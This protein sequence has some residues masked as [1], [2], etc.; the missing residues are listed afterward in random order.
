[1]AKK[2][3]LELGA[4]HL[5]HC[6]ADEF[7]YADT[8]TIKDSLDIAVDVQY[9]EVINYLPP[10]RQA[11]KFII[12]KFNFMN[13]KYIVSEPVS[14]SN[15]NKIKS[16]QLLLYKYPKKVLTNNKF[17]D[18]EYGNHNVKNTDSFKSKDINNIHIHHFPIRSYEHFLKKVING[19][20]AYLNNPL[21]DSNI[22]WHW[23]EWY[24]IYLDN[25]LRI[26]YDLISLKGKVC[27][28][29]QSSYLKK[30]KVPKKIILAKTIYFF[31]SKYDLIL[32]FNNLM[33]RFFK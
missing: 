18:I 25:K 22:G 6:D 20:K 1:M 10:I 31:K 21:K 28:F 24:K 4:S 26:E 19:G 23:K 2:A 16:H 13:F 11:P 17:I 8:G 30:I 12:N 3:V 9:V 33:Q 5:F 14:N 15:G 29:E 32:G 7:W 27:F